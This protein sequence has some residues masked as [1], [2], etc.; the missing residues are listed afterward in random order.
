M[1]RR[2]DPRPGVADPVLRSRIPH[3]GVRTAVYGM[4]VSLPL[5]D[6]P[7]AFAVVLG[8]MG[9]IAG[10]MLIFFRLRHWI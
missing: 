9:G 6:T 7:Y 1:A 10:T 2:R 3:A 4:N 5:S 8:I